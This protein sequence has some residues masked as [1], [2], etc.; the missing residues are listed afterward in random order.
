ML[1]KIIGLA[2]VVA[3]CL[4]ALW[5][6]RLA[7]QSPG[8]RLRQRVSEMVQDFND[9][10]GSQGFLPRCTPVSWTCPVGPP[11][12]TCTRAWLTFG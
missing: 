8:E 6:I 4:F 5:R 10:Q 3:L 1:R 7:L 12:K 11:G 9:G 2:L